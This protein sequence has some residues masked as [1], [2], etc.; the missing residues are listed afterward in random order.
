V[1][2]YAMANRA[3]RSLAT[4]FRVRPTS[5]LRAIQRER[6]PRQAPR[7]RLA[8]LLPYWPA[9]L[10]TGLA[11]YLVVAG[12]TLAVQRMRHSPV[13]APQP[14]AAAP[15]SKAMA[16]M[17]LGPAPKLQAIIL[18]S[19]DK[20]PAPATPSPALAELMG[21]VKPPKAAPVSD[22]ELV[23]ALDE[24]AADPHLEAEQKCD[25]C[26]TSIKFMR[27]PQSA[28]RRAGM[29]E[30]LVFLLHVSGNFEDTKFT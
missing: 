27:S 22:P 3:F 6:P 11:S 12:V 20:V 13:A 17:A 8:T 25:T 7:F 16:A 15:S 26:G 23:I 28:A 9:L 14:A 29:E 4:T 19:P 10:G 18:P 24:P 1:E 30:K 5:R 21:T 2:D